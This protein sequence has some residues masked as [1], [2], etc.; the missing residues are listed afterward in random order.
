MQ[1]PYAVL[2]VEPGAPASDVKK[3]YRRLARM[4]HP[5]KN[6]APE[7]EAKFREIASA[8]EILGDPEKRRRHDLRIGAI[9]RGELPQ[10]YIDDVADA[11]ERA[12]RWIREGVLPHYARFHRGIGAEMAARLWE[13]QDELV[14]PRQLEPGGFWSQRVAKTLNEGVILTAWLR[15]A[16]E[17]TVL[18]RGQGF[19]E[20]AVVPQALWDAGFR[21]SGELDDAVMRL[22]LARV[23]Q[24]V[25]AGRLPAA[26]VSV[27]QARALDDAQ[28]RAR[29]LRWAGWALVAGVL[30]LMLTSGYFQW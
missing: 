2:E 10:E 4:W 5:D 7:A 19:W 17:P 13:D 6:D 30:G 26:V 15:S 16:A 27:E 8:W 23:A 20:V 3:A 22:L 29:N 9:E 24:V 28:I 14:T 21:T 12:E 25:S 18:V 11:I 1:D